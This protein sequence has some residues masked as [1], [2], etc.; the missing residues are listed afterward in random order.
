MQRPLRPFALGGLALVV[1]GVS[2]NVLFGRD[3]P[4]TA[5]DVSILFFFL[6]VAGLITLL[7]AGM[8]AITRRVRRSGGDV[9]PDRAGA[10]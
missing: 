8:I 2:E 4:G 7:I 9:R 10:R 1:A 6:F 5:H 3:T